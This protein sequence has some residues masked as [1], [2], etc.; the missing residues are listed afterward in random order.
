MA[1]SE[2]VRRPRR[3]EVNAAIFSAIVGPPTLIS[4]DDV[5]NRP[6]AFRISRWT[7][8]LPQWAQRVWQDSHL[9]PQVRA[10][11][12]PL[13]D[14]ARKRWCEARDR[15]HSHPD[16]SRCDAAVPGS[17]VDGPRPRI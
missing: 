11:L 3:E 6:P 5:A 17:N 4:P 7:I 16:Q 10:R 15:L 13:L 2:P 1:Q 8:T 9:H 12:L 14:Q